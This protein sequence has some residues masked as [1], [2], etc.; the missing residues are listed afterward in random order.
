MEKLQ[1]TTDYSKFVISTTNRPLNLAGHRKLRE[2]METHGFNPARP[3]HVSGNNGS[4]IVHDGQH[5]LTFAKELGLPVYYIHSDKPY[6]LALDNDTVVKWK[7][8][9]YAASF[10]SC[11]NN[12]YQE[13]V[14]FSEKY[15]IPVMTAAAALSGTVSFS[16]VEHKFKSG[17]FAI[18]DRPYANLVGRV[19]LCLCT[20]NKKARCVRL[21]E[22][23][24]QVCR[25][26]EFD[27]DRLIHRATTDPHLVLQ[28]PTQ[29]AYVE[30]LE[31][32]YNFRAKDQFPLKF[33]TEQAMRKRNVTQSK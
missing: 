16:N 19:F 25:V 12:D 23:L 27:A 30:M 17:A 18:K 2:S 20:I 26:P 10:A 3:I 21:V 9:D 14:E 6:D 28:S 32:I 29:V 24:L 33:A 7:A 22:A 13:V 8:I 11:G 1:C 5:R 31:R 15:A 4:L